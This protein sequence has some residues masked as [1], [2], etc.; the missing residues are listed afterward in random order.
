MNDEIKRDRSPKA[1]V[2]TLIEAVEL[3]KKLQSQ[4]GRAKVSAETVSKAI[5]HSTITGASLTKIASLSQYQLIDREKGNI[6]ISQLA[7]RILHPTSNEQSQQSLQQAALAPPV[8]N[9]LFRDYRDS[10]EEVITS[11]LVQNGFTIDRAKRVARVFKSNAEYLSPDSTVISS[12][13]YEDE[14]VNAVENAPSLPTTSV[15][16]GTKMETSATV[17]PKQIAALSPSTNVLAHYVIPLGENEATLMFT[18]KS[19]SPEDFSALI[20]Y[21]EL[22][23]KQFERRQP[24]DTRQSTTE[25]PVSPLEGNR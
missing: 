12:A 16:T 5:G 2:I 14:A 7:V 4:I 17:I 15:S 3:V 21:V 9:E 13:D 19:L 18:G 8:F 6:L 23:K 11:H 24:K 1:P 22:F 20:D 25:T 10:S